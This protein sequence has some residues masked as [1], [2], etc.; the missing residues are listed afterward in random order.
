MFELLGHLAPA[1]HLRDLSAM[2]QHPQ[3]L[4]N[5]S[6]ENALTTQVRVILNAD[7]VIKCAS[8][9]RITTML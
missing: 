1:G 3:E 8:G 7:V 4:W 9:A 5:N 6:E 2:Q